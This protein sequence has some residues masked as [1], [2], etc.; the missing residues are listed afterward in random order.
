MILSRKSIY[1][2]LFLL[3]FIIGVLP[4]ILSSFYAYHNSREALLNAAIK[5]QEFKTTTGMRNIVT[6]FVESSI[7][8]HLTSHHAAF[9]HYF[10][11]PEKKDIY[12]QAQETDL[13]Y[14]TSHSPDLIESAGFA[15]IN[16]KIISAVFKGKVATH[17]SIGIDLSKKDF[18]TEAVK[19]KEDE[20]YTGHPEFSN[21]SNTWVMTSSRPVFSRNGIKSG[22]LY[23]NIYLD[24]IAKL[25]SN[26]SSPEDIV[27]V[28]N[29]KG[30]L[31]AHNKNYSGETM[32]LVYKPDDHPS[33][34]TAVQQMMSGIDG[35]MWIILGGKEYYITYKNI[36]VGRK[37]DRWSI[38]II[39][40]ADMIY[41]HI[42]A[43]NYIYLI[44][45]SSVIIFAL[46]RI[47]GGSIARPIQDLTSSS[48]AMSKGDLTKRVSTNRIDEIGQL[49]RAF[50]EMAESVQS[51]HEELIRLSAI[52]G[53]TGL[54]NHREF[55]KRLEEE[56]K[57]AS[58]YGT[59]LSL[60]M[61]DIDY[62]KRFNDAYGHQTGDLVLRLISAAM[63]QE[64]R[65]YDLAAR[66]GGEEMAIILPETGNSEAF[67]FSERIRKQ[68]QEVPI[69][70]SGSKIVHVTVSIGIASF[71][72][73]ASSR[74]GLIEAA[75][76]ALYFAKEHG[77]NKTIHYSETLSESGESN[78][79]SSV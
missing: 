13:L 77:R 75:D 50:N 27:F 76:Q 20:I 10:E 9:I 42:S 19:L 28:V 53:L 73:D 62:F 51:S 54:H 78:K 65:S 48:I 38:G 6:L 14:L 57:R 29:E 22:F 34:R 45:F 59:I 58:R 47:I 1:T 44:L 46:A 39:T 36:P 31:I 8:I 25:I 67:A 35:G 32:S 71:P 49:A 23:M 60:L 64:V 17:R 16:G 66:Y 55:Q 21:A 3:F 61:I 70:V 79:G 68:I 30:Q 11:E 41:A 2:K 63:L 43:K 7:N 33:F 52:D 15:D 72:E 24:S 69:H 12:R 4:L 18:F 37:H 74:E 56:V 40:P 5:E 26:I